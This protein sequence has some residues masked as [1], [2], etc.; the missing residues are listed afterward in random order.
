MHFRQ[1][2]GSFRCI[3]Y[4]LKGQDRCFLYE[5]VVVVEALRIP[6]M[7]YFSHSLHRLHSS[8]HFITRM[9][10]LSYP[11]CNTGVIFFLRSPFF[12]TRGVWEDLFSAFVSLLHLNPDQ[13]RE[14][15]LFG[16]HILTEYNEQK[17][18]PI[19]PY[20]PFKLLCFLRVFSSVKLGLFWE[21]KT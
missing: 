20:V 1:T 9:K 5:L 16:E 14:T 2:E 18:V 15:M 11:F 10:K 12:S 21:L 13:R 4:M 7:S 8:I 3:V 19:T 6:F 17:C